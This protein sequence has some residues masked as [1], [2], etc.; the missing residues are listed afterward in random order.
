MECHGFDHCSH[1]PH[2]FLNTSQEPTEAASA[3]AVASSVPSREE[4]LGSEKMAAT[5][6][7]VVIP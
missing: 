4:P 5:W 7:V 6:V 2:A 1:E 3:S